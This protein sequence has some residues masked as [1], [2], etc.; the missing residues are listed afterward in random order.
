MDRASVLWTTSQPGSGSVT[1]TGPGVSR[2][3]AASQKTFAPADTREAATF[4]QYQADVTGLPA[5]SQ[6]N[7]HVSMDGQPLPDSAAQF[8]TAQTGSFSFL[9]FGD[10]GEDTP[11][12]LALIG[13]MQAEPNVSM[14][15]H[16]GD[17]SYPLGDFAN[18]EDSYFR[19]NAPLMRQLP[20][21]PTPGNHDNMVP[22]LTPYLAIHA[23]PETN[24]VP[25]ADAGH[26]Y[27]FDWGD[28]HF[29]NVDSN[30]L[31][32]EAAPR[33]LK[34][35]D[36]DLGATDKYW[37]I[38]YF[39]H[40]PFPTGFHEGDPVCVM[41][42][43]HLNPIVEKHAVQLVLSGHEH[44]FERTHP[45]LHTTYVI[46][47]GGGAGLHNVSVQPQTAIAMQNYNYARVDVKGAQL[48]VSAMGL[49]GLPFDQVTLNPAPIVPAGGIVCRGAFLSIFGL[50][51][52]VQAAADSTGPAALN[53]VSVRV[54]GH[55]VPLLYVSPKQINCRIPQQVAG[56]A[57]IEV[58]TP[59][60]SVL[61]SH[62]FRS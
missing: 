3:V 20:F 10:S 48:T 14:V 62:K 12:Q 47:G 59:N 26:Y 31:G 7:Y 50:N 33:M 18:Y 45:Q 32:T 6:F 37:K 49:N 25:A 53:G 44:A 46:T 17:L 5:G 2:T 55:T 51:F 42:Q 40:A 21:F 4:Y 56:T 15:V 27:S 23:L 43:Q 34:W 16:V 57:T 22:G 58:I 29:A 36:L 35:L 28:A 60:G 54:N 1:V 9:A 24:G 11:Q 19:M 38:V 52:A 8:R 30:L 39:H 41:A 13:L 61:R